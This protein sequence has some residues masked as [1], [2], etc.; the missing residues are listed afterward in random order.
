MKMLY[1]LCNK[2]LYKDVKVFIKEYWK[3]V[4]DSFLND[5][6]ILVKKIE[7]DFDESTSLDGFEEIVDDQGTDTLTPKGL[8]AFGMTKR[9]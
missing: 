6:P 4:M 3:D 9:I 5:I 2:P 7:N 8:N 1:T